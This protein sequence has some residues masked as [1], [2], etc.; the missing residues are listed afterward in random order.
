M[1]QRLPLARYRV[2]S[3]PAGGAGRPQ[4]RRAY[5]PMGRAPMVSLALA[6][7]WHRGD[8]NSR[9]HKGHW[10]GG[11]CRVKFIAKYVALATLVL[12][13][14]GPLCYAH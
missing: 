6:G 9:G 13:T 3:G 4:G 7:S 2:A 8:G 1:R 10:G 14:I 12:V 5:W 11:S